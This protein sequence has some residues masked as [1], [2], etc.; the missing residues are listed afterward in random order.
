MKKTLKQLMEERAAKLKANQAL[1][2]A[3]DTEQRDLSDAE[4]TTF[5]NTTAEIRALDEQIVRAKAIEEQ[6]AITAG[7]GA[8]VAGGPSEREHRD[9]SGYS[10]TRALNAL[11]NNRPLDGLEAEMHQEAQ[12]QLRE[13]GAQGGGNLAIPQMVLQSSLQQRSMSATGQTT[14]P[15]D[16]GGQAIQTNVGGFIERLRAKLVL[17]GMGTT[18]LDGLVGNLTFPKFNANDNAAEKSENATANESSPTVSSVSM[19]PRRLPVFTTV[20]RQLLLQTSASVDAM[21]QDDLAFQLAQAMDQSGILKILNTA[22]IGSV[23]GGANGA[24]PTWKNIVDL[25]TA[26]SALNADMGNLGYLTNVK[27]RGILKQTAKMGNT[28]AQPIWEGDNTLNGYRTGVSTQVPGTLNKGTANGLCSAVIFGNFRDLVQGQW[29]G[30]E[31]LVNPY[32]GDKEGLIRINAWTF[33]DDMVRRAE[34]FAAMK[35]ALTA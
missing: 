10:L 11:A 22:G 23:V 21:L 19:A 4:A 32:A 14:T 29:G 1:L 27:V 12:R 25:E 28:I 3:A 5:D 20:S 18:Q 15:G 34:S 26:V 35:D 8:P 30:M 13:A 31:F 7:L 6:R 16:L 24:A 2:T 17:A 9:F 33:F